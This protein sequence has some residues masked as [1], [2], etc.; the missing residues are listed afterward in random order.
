MPT[1]TSRTKKSRTKLERHPE[2]EGVGAGF[3]LG[4]P[5]DETG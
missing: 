2:L 5:G 4:L 1:T 3:A